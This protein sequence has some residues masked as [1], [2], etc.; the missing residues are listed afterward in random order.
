VNQ[1][2][3]EDM[4]K[5]CPILAI[6]GSIDESG[7]SACECQKEKCQLWVE[8]KNEGPRIKVAHCGLVREG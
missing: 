5:I 6:A 7:N 8:D 2:G 1:R 3:K 4:E